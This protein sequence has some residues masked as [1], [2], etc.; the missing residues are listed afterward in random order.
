MPRMTLVGY[1]G[2]GKSTVGEL[3]ARRLGCGWVDADVVL[4][5][6]AG[7]TIATLVRDRG[8]PEFRAAEAALLGELLDRDDLVLAT[9]GGVVLR[10]EN[11]RLLAERGRP[12]VW[13]RA[14]AAVIRARLAAD[15]ATRDRRP[16]LSGRD[17]LDEVETALLEREPLYRACADLVVDAATDEPATIADR[18]GVWLER[19]W[20]T[21]RSRPET[22]S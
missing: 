18:L 10:P 9:G 11:R 21:R 15:P 5:E 2:T 4:E 3:L 16:A 22:E 14:P 6:R 12:V 1:R 20:S 19:D 7:C 17:P 13:L 8:E